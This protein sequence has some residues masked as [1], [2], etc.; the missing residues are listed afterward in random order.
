MDL[1]EISIRTNGFAGNINKGQMDLQRSLQREKTEMH[2]GK[3][4]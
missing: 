2:T 3:Q 1:Q 4:F